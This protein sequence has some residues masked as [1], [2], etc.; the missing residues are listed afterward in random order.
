[1][2]TTQWNKIQTPSN[3]DSFTNLTTDLGTLASKTNAVVYVASSAER[4]ALAPPGG[5]YAGMVVSRTD[6]PGAA[7]QTY[8]GSAWATQQI[9]KAWGNTVI[10]GSA[11]GLLTNLQSGAVVPVIQGGTAVASTDAAGNLAIAYPAAFPNGVIAS[12]AMNGDSNTG[13]L[14]MAGAGAF[15]QTVST[16]YINVKTANTGAIV[17]S[18]TVRVNWVALGW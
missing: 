4:D 13:N 18:S 11:S 14:L 15:T 2:S 1:M 5:K 7:L 3:P 10:V 9:M 12:V 6:L 8:D 16:L 17:A